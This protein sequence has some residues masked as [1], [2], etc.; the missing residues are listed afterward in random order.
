M[1]MIF[2]VGY[3]WHVLNYTMKDIRYIRPFE[4]SFT[5]QRVP[6]LEYYSSAGFLAPGKLIAFTWHP[7]YKIVP[8]RWFELKSGGPWLPRTR[9]ENHYCRKH[10]YKASQQCLSWLVLRSYCPA[11]FLSKHFFAQYARWMQLFFL[12]EEKKPTRS[13]KGT[14]LLSKIVIVKYILLILLHLNN[15]TG[16]DL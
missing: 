1:C 9:I 8:V 6:R 10:F 11:G 15:S 5:E 4:P 7:R 16:N 2:G 13:V 14:G 3:V 12:R